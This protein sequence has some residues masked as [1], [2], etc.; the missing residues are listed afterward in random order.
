MFSIL[1]PH[2]IYISTDLRHILSYYGD[3]KLILKFYPIDKAKI[4]KSLKT[5][6]KLSKKA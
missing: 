1:S 6:K 4:K 3:K 5:F 2:V